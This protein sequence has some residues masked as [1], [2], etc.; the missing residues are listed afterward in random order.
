MSITK[1]KFLEKI[2]NYVNDDN[3]SNEKEFWL[4]NKE[5]ITKIVESNTLT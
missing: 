2:R 3:I 1:E 4:E 5:D